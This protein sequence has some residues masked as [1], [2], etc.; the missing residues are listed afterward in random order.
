MALEEVTHTAVAI[1]LDVDEL[2]ELGLSRHLSG[3]AA[4]ALVNKA[5]NARGVKPWAET[6]I[7]IFA[8]NGSL[9]LLARPAKYEHFRFRFN[10]AEDM[11]TAAALCPTDLPAG[12]T[13]S[14]ETFVLSVLSTAERVPTPLFEYGELVKFSKDFTRH[15]EEHGDVIIAENAIEILQQIFS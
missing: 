8:L 4:R 7:E 9:L 2:R 13:Y 11:L 1:C 14:D 15:L 6:E 5:L 12:L 3:N 10:N